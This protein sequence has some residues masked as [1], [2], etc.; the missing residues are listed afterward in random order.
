MESAAMLWRR[1]DAAGHD[2]CRLVEGTDGGFRLDGAATFLL[3]GQ[4]ACLQYRVDCDGRWRARE[5]TVQ[6]WI[7]PAEIQLRVARSTA[8][9]WSL[10]GRTIAGCDD[11]LDLDFGFT[12]ATNLLQ[13][14]RL[15]LEVGQAADVPVAW[16]DAAAGTLDRLEQ[17][18][19]RR[20]AEVYRYEARRFN[21]AARLQINGDGFV[22][23]YPGLWEGE[24]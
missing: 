16:L 18:Y 8:G 3:E 5:G 12:P 21:Y 15:A 11:C 19:Q 2:A 7:G 10:N 22:V 9:L 20:A 17:R 24:P 13:V 1:L 4:I 23:K 14:R 6:G